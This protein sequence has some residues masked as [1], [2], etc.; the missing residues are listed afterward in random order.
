MFYRWIEP[1][2]QGVGAVVCAGTSFLV[3]RSALEQVGGFETG[4][5]SEDL[6]TGIRL[7]AAGH[8]IL[9]LNEKLS[10]GLAPPSLAAMARQRSRWASGTLQTLRTTANPLVIPG[11]NPLQRLAFLE[12]ILH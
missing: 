7:S 8:R 2:R 6:A 3:R 1:T 12:G 4:T 9:Y 5:P 10:A 11:L